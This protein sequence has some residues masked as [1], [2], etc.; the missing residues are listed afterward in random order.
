VTIGT[1]NFDNRSFALDEESNI[2]VDAALAL[3]LENI[4]NKDLENC[5]RIALDKWRHRGIRKR[6]F[7]A[8]CV[9]LKEQI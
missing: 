8:T 6:I 2:C 4:F 5:E 9:F 3:E 1:T 7:G